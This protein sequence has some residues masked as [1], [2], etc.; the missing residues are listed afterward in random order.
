[1]RRTL[2]VALAALILWI[3]WDV[4]RGLVMQWLTSPDASYGLILAGVA[5]V[6]VWRRRASLQPEID[7]PLASAAALLTVAASCALFLAGTVAADLFVTRASL[8]ALAGGLVWFLAGYRVARRLAAPL[9]FLVLAI[10]LPELIVNAITLPLQLVASALAEFVLSGAGVPVFRDGN[11]LE[12]P[13]V[14]LQVAE[15]CS[16]LRS[17]LS[18]TCVA[19]L[20]AWSARTTLSR[21]IAIV[22]VA[23]PIAVVANGLRI[24]ATGMATEVW[25]PAAARGAWHE[26]TGWVTFVVSLVALLAF[27]RLSE[28]WRPHLFVKPS[29][30]EA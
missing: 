10:P 7:Y 20:L 18:L 25:G 24:A 29:M 9:A 15:A 5:G 16:G 4:L 12:L 28:G 11:V 19:V 2:V 8:V 14:T 27:Y 1:M 23:I 30:A 13:A 26:A 6:L 17:A 21:R 3:A 22:L